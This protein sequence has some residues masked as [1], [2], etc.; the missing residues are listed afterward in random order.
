[1]DIQSYKIIKT[2]D[3]WKLRRMARA[4][5]ELRMKRTTA[6]VLSF[7]AL[8]VAILA[9]IGAVGVGCYIMYTG[10]EAGKAFNDLILHAGLEM[11]LVLVPSLLIC[12]E[13][14]DFADRQ[15]YVYDEEDDEDYETDKVDLT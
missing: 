3:Y 8:V 11:M 2:E 13:L 4:N 9:I 5:E 6:T 7:A 10:A 15:L 1:M 12:K 14:V